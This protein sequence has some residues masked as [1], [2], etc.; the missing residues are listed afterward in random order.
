LRCS[1]TASTKVGKESRLD[2]LLAQALVLV[3]LEGAAIIPGDP[4][5][6]PHQLF[7]GGRNPTPR[8]KKCD[9]GTSK[10]QYVQQAIGELR[11]DA[12]PVARSPRHGCYSQV[13]KDDLWEDL[14]EMSR[15]QPC[16]TVIEQYPARRVLK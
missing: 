7:Q 4:S 1:G 12:M 6:Q 15:H 13:Q 16:V 14:F 9:G 3:L 11:K 8:G 10:V 2:S 5:Y